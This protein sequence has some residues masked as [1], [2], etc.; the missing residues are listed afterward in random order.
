LKHFDGVFRQEN[1]RFLKGEKLENF[2][3]KILLGWGDYYS[4]QPK[5][6]ARNKV[7]FDLLYDL[8]IHEVP[9]EYLHPLTQ[10]Q[11]EG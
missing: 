7:Y 4:K 11:L 5:F 3:E 10:R 1:K 8:L 6:K 2:D 9:R